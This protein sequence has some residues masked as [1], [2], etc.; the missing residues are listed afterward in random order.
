MASACRSAVMA[1]ARS[2]AARSKTPL[3]KNLL[4]PK[5]SP[6]SPFSSSTR[7]SA[8]SRIAAVLGSVESMMPLHSVIASARLRSSIAVDS[9]CWSLLSQVFRI[10]LKKRNRKTL[11]L[12]RKQDLLGRGD[13]KLSWSTNMLLKHSLASCKSFH[14]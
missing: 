6:P 2:V 10:R 1:G 11:Y 8:A 5:S 12:G 4:S 14:W 7:S 9:T 13:N 3:L